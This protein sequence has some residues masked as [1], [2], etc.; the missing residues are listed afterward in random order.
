MRAA[1]LAVL[2]T[3]AVA[4]GVSA[5]APGDPVF[6]VASI[7]ENKSGASNSSTGTRPGGAFVASNVTLRQLIIS[8]YRLRRFQV[9]GGPGWLD[10]ER[11]DINARAPEG[12]PQ[13]Q[14]QA[15]QR[16]LLA[17]RFTLKVHTETREQP[18]Y[19]LVLARSDGTLGPQLKPSRLDCA[20]RGPGATPAPPPPQNS[21][22]CGMNSSTTSASGKM[23]GGGR[24]MEDLAA[25]LANFAAERMVVDRT[26]LTGRYDLEVQWTP[27]T[28]RAGAT[29]AADAGSLFTAL[30]EQLGL[31]LE[32]QRGPVE[33]LVVDSAERPT[34]D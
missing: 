22:S 14:L 18:I 13:S 26:G 20:P 33:Y 15:M 23:T 8:A 17:D 4:I 1:F 11:F 31:K 9:T 6:E 7:K 21:L 2:A 32:S 10:S 34:P 19:A 24:T 28:A 3:S 16:T 25:A 5:Q 12:A 27:D 29:D 30:Q